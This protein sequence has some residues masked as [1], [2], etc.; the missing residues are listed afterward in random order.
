M[1]ERVE[2]N[3]KMLRDILKLFS[4]AGFECYEFYILSYDFITKKNF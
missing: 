1:E 3:C 2:E 4:E